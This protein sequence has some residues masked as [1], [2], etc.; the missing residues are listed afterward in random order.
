MEKR[1]EKKHLINNQIRASKVMLLGEDGGKLGEYSLNQA[2][3]KADALDLD[4]MQ[5]GQNGDVSICKIVNYSSWA[6]HEQK[7]KHKQEVKNKSHEMKC[8]NFRPSIGDNDFNRNIKKIS[9]FLG[10]G[11]KVKVCVKFKS[12]RET[13]MT[14]LNKAFVQRI[15]D[16]LVSF[17]EVDGKINNMGRDIN[18]IVKPVKR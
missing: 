7:R 11:H 8:I 14:D 12:F 4:L 1:L 16:S 15:N 2:L 6:Y 10:E 9:E 3:A 5:V 18:Y 17:G 13:T